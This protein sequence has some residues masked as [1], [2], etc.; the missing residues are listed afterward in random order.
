MERN[1]VV[2]RQD[3]L[4]V[5]AGPALD[6]KTTSQTGS[7]QQNSPYSTE[8]REKTS[9]PPYNP[10]WNNLRVLHKNTLPPRSHF[11]IYNN[12]TDALSRDVSKSKTHSLSGTWSK[13]MSLTTSCAAHECVS[14]FNSFL[15]SSEMV[16][17]S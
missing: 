5:A 1:G 3:H 10:D 16:K 9:Y 4:K 11:H 8:T 7:S 2:D 17:L 12:V 13:F 14:L 6:G 15:P